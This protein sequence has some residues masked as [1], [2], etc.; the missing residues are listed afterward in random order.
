M[1]AEHTK[2]RILSEALTL[3]A[4]KGYEAVSVEEIAAAV[5]SKPLPCTSTTRGSGTSLT[6]LS[7]T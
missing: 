6:T 2:E 7:P 3:F 5:A 4:Q 1:K